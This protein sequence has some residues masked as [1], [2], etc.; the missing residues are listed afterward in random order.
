MAFLAK[1][2]QRVALAAVGGLI[3]LAWLAWQC[4]HNPRIYFLPADHRAEWIIFPASVSAGSYHNAP[5]DTVFHRRFILPVAPSDAELSIRAAKQFR[6]R[7]NG[8]QLK[9][10]APANWKEVTVAGLADYLRPGTDTIDVAVVNDDAPPALWLALTA[11]DLTLRSDATW[12]VS[13]TDSAWRRATLAAQPR[14]PGPGNPASGGD[15]SLESMA[16]V[17]PIWLGLGVLAALTWWIGVGW[18]KRG[19]LGTVRRGHWSIILLATGA[20]VFGCLFVH[21]LICY[22]AIMGFDSPA[23]R[24]YVRYIQT[25][26]ALPWPDQG[27]EMYQPP[28][29]YGAAALVLDVLKCAVDSAMGMALLRGFGLITGLGEMALIFLCLRE[30]FPHR[31][32]VALMGTALAAFVPMHLYMVN[33]VSN[34]PFEAVLVTGSVF[35][36]LKLLKKPES[37]WWLYGALGGALG[38]AML[39]KVTAVL[40][41]PIILAACGARLI[42]GK[43]TA[44]RLVQTLGV[45]VLTAAI[46]CGWYYVRL[47]HRYGSPIIGNWDPVLGFKWW[48]DPGYRTAGDYLR[49]GRSLT[50]PFFSGMAGFGDGIY[51]TLWGDGLYS[52]VGVTAS[53][54]AWNFQLMA[55]GYLLALVPTGVLFCGAVVSLARFFRRPSAQMF[56][57]LALPAVIGAGMIY[58]SLKVPSFAQAKAFYGLCLLAPLGFFAAAGWETLTRG[59]RLRQGILG[60]ALCVWLANS[61]AAMWIRSDGSQLPLMIEMEPGA[62]TDTHLRIGELRATLERDPADGEAR[63]RLAEL[64]QKLGQ[65]DE[66]MAEARRAVI[67]DPGNPRAHLQLGIFLEARGEFSAA[68]EEGLTAA[69]VGPDCVEVYRHLPAWLAAVGRN[70]DAVAAMREGLALAPRDPGLHDAL[71]AELLSQGQ[72]PAAQAHF[73]CALQLQPHF[74]AAEYHLG[75]MLVEDQKFTDAI[76]H[77]ASFVEQNS[78]DAGG[79]FALATAQAENGDAADA[80]T[81]LEAVVTLA[82]DSPDLLGQVAWLLATQPD[83]RLRNGARAVQLAERARDL[84]TQ[85]DARLFVTLAAAYAEAGRFDDATEAA[86]EALTLAQQANDHDNL[87]LYQK[88]LTTVSTKQKFRDEAATK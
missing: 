15:G 73:I 55:A 87:P 61:V 49:F 48:Q 23:H 35:L 8:V 25:H 75:R 29:Y 88:M 30:A 86:R 1:T 28:L 85:K 57:W 20:V 43:A 31:R 56:L 26:H 5:L 69:R 11:G 22:P 84:A 76:P 40:V 3:A 2:W 64:L 21:N 41:A 34:E 60:V 16:A 65:S 44:Q 38:A 79:H 63:W 42:A 10:T 32:D 12:D 74:D 36:A 37:R 46:V 50:D 17:W 6:I 53:R 4:G 19:S 27:W 54:P 18:L 45:T 13:A 78:S 9:V 59:H 52:G 66:A 83:V 70:A 14:L 33:C 58:M 68:V 67:D 81:N 51:S 77:L 39:A 72:R 82:P 71:G 47:W 24:D 62:E 7:I 80:K